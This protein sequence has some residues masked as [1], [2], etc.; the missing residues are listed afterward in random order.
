MDGKPDVLH[1]RLGGLQQLG[2]AC[3]KIGS[4]H[5]ASYTLRGSDLGSTIVVVVTASNSLGSA[6]AASSPT[7]VVNTPG[8]HKPANT[9]LPSITGSAVEGQTLKA[10]HGTWTESPTSYAYV[11]ED[12]NSS[13]S[14][15]SSVSGATASSFV[16]RA[17]DVG[18][19]IRVVVTA[20]NSVGSTQ[21]TAAATALVTTPGPHAPANTSLPT[22]SGSTIEG[23]TLTASHGSWSESPTSYAYQWER[24]NSSGGACAELPGSVSGTYPPG[25]AD[26]GST[27]RSW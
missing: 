12:C 16:L 2:V 26:V 11:W 1:L 3:T 6:Q 18:H 25:A 19:T 13:G 4:A 8:P 7:D 22:I 21:A 20:G 14:G 10:A 9:S 5:S 23:Q 17:A 15:C 27:L 24:C